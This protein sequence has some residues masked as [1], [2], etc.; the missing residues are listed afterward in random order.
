MAAGIG[1]RP[2]LWP[3]GAGDQ[4]G[5]KHPRGGAHCC[6]LRGMVSARCGRMRSILRCRSKSRSSSTPA[7][8][9]KVARIEIDESH[10][11]RLPVHTPSVM[12]GVKGGIA[13]GA[14]MIVPAL[15][16]GLIALPQHLVC[17]KSAGRSGSCRLV[18][19][20]PRGDHAL[21]PE[22]ADLRHHHPCRGLAADRPALWRHAA[23]AAAAPDPAGRHHRPGFVDRRASFRA[24]PDQS[25][26]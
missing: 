7:V 12:A 4:R 15:L 3:R 5:H 10:R 24:G 26:S 22:R 14:A 9:T 11:A 6:R 23:H 16:Y 20:H 19:S 8:R 17:G 25:L 18:Q 2:D 1:P 21:P 13:G